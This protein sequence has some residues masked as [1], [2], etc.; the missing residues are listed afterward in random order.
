MKLILAST[1]PRRRELLTTLDVPFDVV[2]PTFVET[3]SERSAAEE[4]LYF[5]EQKARSIAAEYSNALILGSDTLIACGGEKLG[6]PRDPADAH[7]ILS[8]LSGRIHELYTAV[9]LLNTASQQCRHHLEIVRVRFRAL[10]EAEIAQY[11]ATGEP[12][13]KAGA[14]AAQEKGQH[15]IEYIEGDRNAVIGLPLDPIK[16]WLTEYGIL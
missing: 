10:S 4:T 1:S 9:A 7:R 12:M 5:A 14:Y 16:A 2:P 13:G 3:N 11:I 8:Y 15:L 6:K